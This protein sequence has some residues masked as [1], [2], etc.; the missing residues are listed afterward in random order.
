MSD[1]HP[2]VCAVILNWNGLED[3]L[4]CLASLDS[5]QLE[6][7][8]LTIV[9]VDNCSEEDPRAV[10]A[11]RFP[12]VQTLRAPYNLGFAGGCNY[13]AELA[14]EQ[15]AHYVL[16]LNNDTKVAPDFLARL[17]EHAEHDKTVG[18]AVPLICEAEQPELVQSCGGVVRLALGQA[19]H[20][21]RGA[22]RAQ[23]ALMP[24]PVDYASGCCVLIPSAVLRAT[25]GFDDRFFAYFEDVE[26][27]LR[28]RAMGLRIVCV[29][30]SVIWHKESASTRRG[31]K[32]GTTSPLKHYLLLR[33]RIATVRRY[34]LW[35]EQIVFFLSVLPAL[36]V[37]YLAAFT[38]RRRWRKLVWFVC[39][40]V[41]G[42]GGRFWVPH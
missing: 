31:L 20:N 40:L 27:S 24:R 1:H 17:L 8:E 16:L 9:V 5:V 6:Q 38:A 32:E 23:V 13:G 22:E 2:S 25:G 11:A 35:W 19:A 15:G 30:T 12:A 37:F 14:L 42:L 29:P 21:R 33:N 41:D 26:L 36:V 34:G 3:T 18:M 7:G 10:I 39:G 28:V 4:D